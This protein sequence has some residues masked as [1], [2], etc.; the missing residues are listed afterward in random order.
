MLERE[1]RLWGECHHKRHSATTPPCRSDRTATGR[2]QG[3]MGFRV[4]GLGVCPATPADSFGWFFRV[5]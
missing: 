5:P 4:S 3:I 2:K 1:L